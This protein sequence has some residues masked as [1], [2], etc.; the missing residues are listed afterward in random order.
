MPRMMQ[1]IEQD[2]GPPKATPERLTRAKQIV[3]LSDRL[4]L[5]TSVS[6]E[7]KGVCSAFQDRFVGS[8]T[9]ELEF[10]LRSILAGQSQRSQL[11]TLG[12][13]LL[14]MQPVHRTQFPSALLQA[15]AFTTLDCD[16]DN[17]LILPVRRP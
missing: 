15:K 1:G 10:W 4:I 8:L 7:R 5:L 9:V 17:D 14:A 2:V 6:A 3:K 12:G 13:V 16:P 11:A